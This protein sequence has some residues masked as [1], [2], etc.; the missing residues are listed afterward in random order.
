MIQDIFV[1]QLLMVCKHQNTA[2]PP[3]SSLTSVQPPQEGVSCHVAR[4][5][6]T[7]LIE[8]LLSAIGLSKYAVCDGETCKKRKLNKGRPQYLN[9]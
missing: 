1:L 7:Q 6:P 3:L 9:S 4:L 5:K 2:N 8:T